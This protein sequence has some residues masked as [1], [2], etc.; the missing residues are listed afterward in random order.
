MKL[1]ISGQAL[2]KTRTLEEVLQVLQRFQVNAIELWPENIPAMAGEQ[3]MK[4]AYRGRDIQKAKEI[5]NRY[6]VDVA[7]VTMGGAFNRDLVMGVEGYARE[8][9]YAVEAARELGAK[10]VNHYCYHICLMDEA[11]DMG[12]IIKYFEPAVK[13]AE[14][15][16]ITLVLENEAHDATRTPEGMLAIVRAV[17]SSRFKVNFDATNFYHASCEGFP[18]AYEVL[19]SHIGYVHLKNGCIFHV[20]SGHDEYAKG[21]IMTGVNEGKYIYYPPLPRGAVNMDGLLY[22]LEMDGYGGYCTLEPH[23]TPEQVE[24]YYCEEVAYLRKKMLFD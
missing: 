7:C 17:D 4:G 12:R 5:L 11:L 13:K 20:G 23:T 16:D 19:K 24:Q 21:S 2:S 1:G 3:Y 22:R 9:V 10:L 15:L 18:H 14:E 6:S 8:L